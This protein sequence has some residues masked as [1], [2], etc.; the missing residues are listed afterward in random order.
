MTPRFTPL[1]ASPGATPRGGTGRAELRTWRSMSFTLQRSVM[2]EWVQITLPLSQF[3]GLLS[4]SLPSPF[5]VLS[6]CYLCVAESTGA[7]VWGTNK[8]IGLPDLGNLSNSGRLRIL[9][10]QK[11]KLRPRGAGDH[12]LWA[13]SRISSITVQ[14]VSG[15]AGEFHSIYLASLPLHHNGQ[16]QQ[17]LP[18]PP[19]LQQVC[20]WETCH[21]QQHAST[22]SS[23]FPIPQS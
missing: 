21:T 10:W 19:S 13:A 12:V 1:I 7:I 18:W 5:P 6:S 15:L 20:P 17:S 23:H 4:R 9:F 8:F 14:W 2:G 11:R 22:S 3:S 16:P